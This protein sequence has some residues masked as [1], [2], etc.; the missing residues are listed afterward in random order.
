MQ[1]NLLH[2]DNALL[3]QPSFID[4]CGRA[5]AKQ[6]NMQSDGRQV[7]LWATTSQIEKMRDQL[8]G[9]MVGLD[10]N[11]PVVTWYG[12]GDFHHVTAVIISLL[13]ERRDAP[14]T[15]VHFDN[16]PDW[17]RYR[18]GI[19]CGSWVHY[20]L[21]SGLVSRVISIGVSSG[22][23]AWP[24]LKGA[25]LDHVASGK[26]IVFPVDPPATWVWRNLASGAA[27]CMDGHR[28][29]WTHCDGVPRPE[30]L[31]T[32]GALI[33]SDAIYVSIDKDVLSEAAAVTNW[34]QGQLGLDS[35]IGWLEGLLTT[36]SVIGVDIVGDYSPAELE[37]PWIT[38][39]LKQSELLLD[40]P[41][42]RVTGVAA[43]AA[44]QATNVKLL[45]VLDTLLC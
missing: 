7:R 43:A 26:L 21:E 22:D 27:H 41:F 3:E 33:G 17:V 9:V 2:L 31:A 1:L 19:H 13:A 5:D 40:Q 39:A 35:L 8:R 29:V 12:S 14:I 15:I 4:L 10:T 25:A 11:D 45:S 37:G 36:Q 16:H 32:L 20:V 24:E 6:I 38:R 18:R 34:D 30:K 23:L 44:N 28:V 42:T